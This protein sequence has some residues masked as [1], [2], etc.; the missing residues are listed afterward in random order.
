MACEIP[1]RLYNRAVHGAD[2]QMWLSYSHEFDLPSTLEVLLV[3]HWLSF[4]ESLDL[5]KRL[6][7]LRNAA[8]QT[9]TTISTVK[10]DCEVLQGPIS[11]IWTP[12]AVHG[13][14]PVNHNCLKLVQLTFMPLHVKG[15]SVSTERKS[16]ENV[17][18]P[19]SGTG[20]VGPKVYCRTG[21]QDCAFGHMK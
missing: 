21:E 9:W 19:M 12:A 10:I 15:F 6:R 20:R 3:F 1:V 2:S 18:C 17:T 13:D 4:V 11:R 14:C 16:L 5:Q 7:A 8:V